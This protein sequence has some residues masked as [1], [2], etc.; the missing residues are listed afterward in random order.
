M[1]H[2]EIQSNTTSSSQ[3]FAGAC[4]GLQRICFWVGI[5]TPSPGCGLQVDLTCTDPLGFQSQTFS[6]LVDGSSVGSTQDYWSA[7]YDG[8]GTYT[9]N[10]SYLGLPGMEYDYIVDQKDL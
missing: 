9:W 7:A 3:S 6:G 1:A 8:V 4:N 10:V 5:R 2:Y